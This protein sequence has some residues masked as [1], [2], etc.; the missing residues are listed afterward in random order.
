M[1]AKPVASG[2]LDGDDRFPDRDALISFHSA[3]V[4]A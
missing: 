3:K 2:T 1:T 4:D